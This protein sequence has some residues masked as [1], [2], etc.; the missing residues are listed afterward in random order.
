MRPLGLAKWALG[1]VSALIA[2]DT[3]GTVGGAAGVAVLVAVVVADAVVVG[4]LGLGVSVSTGRGVHCGVVVHPIRRRH[5]ERTQTTGPRII[6]STP[7]SASGRSV[8]DSLPRRS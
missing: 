5:A 1:K 4:T 6:S 2:P 7:R 8:S 3:L